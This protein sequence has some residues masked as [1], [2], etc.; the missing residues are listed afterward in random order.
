MNIAIPIW[1][2]RV[3]PV[4]DTAANVVVFADG[5]GSAAP[6]TEYGLAGADFFSRAH[7]MQ[8]LN[9]DVLICGAISKP[10]EDEIRRRGI[11]VIP[12]ICGCVEDV[13]QAF[14][15]GQLNQQQFMM[16]GCCGKRRRFQRR[17][18]GQKRRGLS[19]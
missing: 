18:C 19:K 7:R 14:Q 10:L 6:G 8:E 16:P 12:H 4:F 13:F 2:H 3:S 1:N 9:I 5:D 11:E 17:G 15:T